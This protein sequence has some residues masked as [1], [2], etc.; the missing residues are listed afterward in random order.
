MSQIPVHQNR[1]DVLPSET[2]DVDITGYTGRDQEGGSADVTEPALD[3]DKDEVFTDPVAEVCHIQR[4]WIGGT[5][6][7]RKS[8]VRVSLSR[9]S[10]RPEGVLKVRFDEVPTVHWYVPVEEEM[11]PMQWTWYRPVSSMLSRVSPSVVQ[12]TLQSGTKGAT[13]LSVRKSSAGYR[14]FR[15]QVG[16]PL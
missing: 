1:F 6:T 10:S 8:G 2:V 9:P 12:K 14:L 16:Y 3:W 15:R 13:V 11:V 4:K 7:G 5:P